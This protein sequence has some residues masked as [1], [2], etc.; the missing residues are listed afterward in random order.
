MI[1]T[2]AIQ[3]L[4]RENNVH[5]IDNYIKSGANEGMIRMDDS[6]MNL[7]K[8]GE[9]TKDD[10]LRYSVDQKVLRISLKIINSP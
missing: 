8:M 1:S 7:F 4:I 9:I 10:T 6:L 3:S 2:P 5:Q